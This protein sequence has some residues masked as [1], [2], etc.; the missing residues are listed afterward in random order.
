MVTSA[1]LV[2]VGAM[3]SCTV[4]VW[5]WSAAALPQLSTNDHVRVI[6]FCPWQLPLATASENVAFS[7]VEQLSASLVTSPVADTEASYKHPASVKMVMSAGLVN[8]GAML[9]CTVMVW[10]W[11]AAALPQP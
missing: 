9:S 7:P 6:I 4:I 5:I 10:I 8:V 11:S 3:L 2:K 1:G